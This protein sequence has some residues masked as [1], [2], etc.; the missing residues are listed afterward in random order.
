MKHSSISRHV[1]VFWLSLTM[2]NCGVLAA[3]SGTSSAIAGTVVDVTG[4]SLPNASVSATD[5]DTGT[6]RTEETGSDGRFLFSQ[7][8]PGTYT[9][10][11]RAG[12]FA[13]QTSRRVAVEVGRTVDT[14][15]QS[16][17]VR[18]GAD[19]R[20]EGRTGTVVPG[21][22]EH[23]DDAGIEN[24]RQPAQPRS[25]PD[26]HRAVCA[27]RADEHRR[28]VE[29]RQGRGR[30]RKRG[31][32]RPACHV[33]RLHPR[34][35]R[36]QRS[37]AGAEYRALDKSRHRPRRRG[38]GD[39]E[40]ELL[41]RR[42][43]TLWRLAGELLHQVGRPTRFTAICTRYGT[44]RCFNAEDYFLH[45]NDTPGNV[46]KK[47]RSNVNEFGVSVGGP[48]RKDKLFFFA[49]YEGVR[50]A[51]PLVTETVAPSPAY[52][53]YVLQQLQTPQGASYPD[54]VTCM[55]NQAPNDPITGDCLPE[56]PGRFRFTRRCSRSTA[57]FQA[58]QRLFSVVRSTRP[59][60][61]RGRLR[62]P[63]AGGEQGIDD[64]RRYRKPDWW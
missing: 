57:M 30:L 64:E 23:H 55:P 10:T 63:E 37:L 45:A 4:A 12:G 42:S 32:Q 1:L 2:V 43:R 11:V 53:T 28:L 40:Y 20:S 26:F 8:N 36:Q 5:G 13:T 47:P 15:L 33:E 59:G 14:E 25:G 52:Q 6:V 49:H 41:L 54:T 18:G 3:Q 16:C 29:R 21:E 62:E 17:C 60:S 19:S 38:S 34:R 24:H 61:A 39:G 7:V 50:M 51:L 56:E 44:A 22:P 27:G 35:V 9:V 58:R 46:A 48:F 31:V